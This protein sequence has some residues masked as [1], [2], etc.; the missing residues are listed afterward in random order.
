MRIGLFTSLALLVSLPAQSA[1]VVVQSAA[2]DAVVR[3]S[4]EKKNFSTEPALELKT[5]TFGGVSEAYLRFDIPDF[6]QFSD[7]VVL[8]LFGQL[9]NPG[10]AQVVVRSINDTNWEENTLAWRWRPEHVTTIGTLQVVGVSAAWYKLDLTSHVKAETAA[11]KRTVSLALVP[12]DG[13][14]IVFNSREAKSHQPEL[15]FSRPLFAAKISFIP[16]TAAPPSGY[17]A[18]KGDAFRVHERGHVYGWSADNRA[19][20]RDR[21]IAKYQK[22]AKNPPVKTPDRRY[23]FFGYMDGDKMTNRVSWEIAV[24]DGTY[25]VKV[26]A[27]DAQKYDSI[28]GITAENVVVVDGLPDKSKRWIEGRGVVTVK[29]GRLTIDNTPSSSNNKMTYVEIS[30]TETLISSQP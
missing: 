20:M 9:G 1:V 3:S 11:G 16:A 26:V 19:F 14:K 28:F 12:S 4:A 5:S 8:R 24:P 17:M 22:D 29:D 2:A 25:K 21:N 15:V 27:G 7:K 10:A 6:A 30:E 23:D 18:D 13:A